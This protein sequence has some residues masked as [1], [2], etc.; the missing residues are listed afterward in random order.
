MEEEVTQRHN[1]E[2]YEDGTTLGSYKKK[3]VLEK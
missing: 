1:T 3:I 2:E